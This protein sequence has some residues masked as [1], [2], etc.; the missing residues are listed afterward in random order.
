M[1]YVEALTNIWKNRI[2][3]GIMMIQFDGRT[4]DGGLEWLEPFVIKDQY[5]K[6]R[7]I[8]LEK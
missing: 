7:F 4:L 8:L 5:E 3:P 1:K 6:R 2:K